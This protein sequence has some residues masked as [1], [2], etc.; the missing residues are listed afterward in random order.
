MFATKL[1]TKAKK[2]I[3]KQKTERKKEEIKNLCFSNQNTLTIT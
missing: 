1:G 3:N 2:F